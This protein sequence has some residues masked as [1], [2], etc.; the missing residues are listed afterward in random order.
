MLVAVCCVVVFGVRCLSYV[1]CYSLFDVCCVLLDVLCC[2]LF[3]LSGMCYWLVVVCVLCVVC[4]VPSVFVLFC[5][6]RLTSFVD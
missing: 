4:R 5:V 3:V 1:A 6:R 2:F